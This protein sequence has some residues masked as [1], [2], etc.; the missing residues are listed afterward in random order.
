MN[1]WKII[2]GNSSGKSVGYTNWKDSNPSGNC[3]YL[4]TKVPVDNNKNS[5]FLII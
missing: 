5:I 1:E 2:G 3:A 4:F